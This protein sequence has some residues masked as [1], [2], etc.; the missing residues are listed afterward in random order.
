MDKIPAI[1]GGVI[2]QQ[3]SE[4]QRNLINALQRQIKIIRNRLIKWEWKSVKENGYPEHNL[5]VL[6]FIPGED[7]HMTSGMWDIDNK[8]VLL[9]EY[10]V[11]E[12]EVTHWTYLPIPPIK[13]L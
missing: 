8:W 13:Q 7:N 1:T 12:E 10:R 2:K 9:D 5:G 4:E 11:P 6:V 3:P